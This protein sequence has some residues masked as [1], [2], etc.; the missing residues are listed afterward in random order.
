MFY[1]FF[2]SKCINI[3]GSHTLATFGKFLKLISKL[4]P[5]GYYY[6][7]IVEKKIQVL[8]TSDLDVGWREQG[9]AP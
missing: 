5:T 8:E 9:R 1:F 4:C 3:P 2:N 7:S 6:V